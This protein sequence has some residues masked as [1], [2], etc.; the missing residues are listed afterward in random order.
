MRHA[1][2]EARQ[3]ASQGGEASA[4]PRAAAFEVLGKLEIARRRAGLDARRLVDHHLFR[5]LAACLATVI[6]I[7]PRVHRCVHVRVHVHGHGH[8]RVHMGMGVGMGV[9]GPAACIW[10]K[11]RRA[12][13]RSST[14]EATAG[15]SAQTNS[16]E[17]PTAPATDRRKSVRVLCTPFGLQLRGTSMHSDVRAL[18]RKNARR[19]IARASEGHHNAVKSCLK[20]LL[21]FLGLLA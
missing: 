8:V 2:Q 7:R 10:S 11:A 5:G 9:S 3:E 18:W 6:Y 14:G 1:R 15:P 13:D 21:L 20:P 19:N 16:D 4:H 17:A 12:G